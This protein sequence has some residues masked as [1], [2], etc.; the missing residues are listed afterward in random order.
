MF[1]GAAVAAA[2]GTLAIQGFQAEPLATVQTTPR[3]ANHIG[4]AVAGVGVTVGASFI[5]GRAGTAKV[6]VPVITGAIAGAGAGA[7]LL[8]PSIRRMLAEH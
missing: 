8:A 2:G 3:G 7:Y 5:A 4:G 6:G 1:A